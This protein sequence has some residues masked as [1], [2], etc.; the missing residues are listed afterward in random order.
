MTI[1]Y[2][3]RHGETIDNANQIMQG[4]TQGELNDNG[5]RQAMEFSREWEDK[6]LD[7]VIAS[8]LKRSIDTARIIAEPHH[9]EVL[10]TPLLRERDWGS[11]TGRFIP[12]L[13][14]EVWPDDVETQENLL[15]RAGEFIAYVRET[16]PGKKVLAVGHGIINK[17]IQ[18]VYYQ[19]PMNEILRMSNVEV[20]TLEL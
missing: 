18:S 9:L 19:K 1:L 16:F 20:R 13:K 4:Q 12:E 2:L 15:S 6:P 11:F 7:V 14:G 10:T 3:V 17:A 8:D 5:I